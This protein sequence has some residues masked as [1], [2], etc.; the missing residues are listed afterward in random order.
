M[1]ENIDKAIVIA[2]RDVRK[3]QKAYFAM[4]RRSRGPGTSG[5]K[6]LPSMLADALDEAKGAERVLDRLLAQEAE[7]KTLFGGKVSADGTI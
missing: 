6:V 5:I 1:I 3:K 4:R 7:G 2:A